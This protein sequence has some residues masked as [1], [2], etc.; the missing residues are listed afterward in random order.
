[1]AAGFLMVAAAGLLSACS[2]LP[3]SHGYAEVLVNTDP[4]GASC[5]LTRAGQPIAT[6]GPTP[7]IALVDPGTTDIGV[8]CQRP[9]FEDASIQVRLP[10]DYE[11]RVD[12]PL[13]PLPPGTP[14]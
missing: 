3:W 4:P 11:R 10:S 6:A 8:T 2:L 13:K 9:A 14:R 7:A 12:I 1:M 5:T